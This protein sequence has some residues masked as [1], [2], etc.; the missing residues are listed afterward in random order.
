MQSSAVQLFAVQ[1]RVLN[2]T[3]SITSPTHPAIASHT[4]PSCPTRPTHHIPRFAPHTA[5]GLPITSH[6]PCRHVPHFQGTTTQLGC[7]STVAQHAISAVPGFKLASPSSSSANS[8]HLHTLAP[9]HWH[10]HHPDSGQRQQVATRK[11]T[12]HE[13]TDRLPHHHG[14][15]FH[16]RPS[17]GLFR[18]G[19]EKLAG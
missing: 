18:D 2:R 15:M 17:R 5:P 8:S 3:S 16:L 1:C 10:R 11:H 6:H 12:C 9:R 13:P 19:T 14:G 4:C 7:E